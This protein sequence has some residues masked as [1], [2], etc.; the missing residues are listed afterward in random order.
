LKLS[1][2]IPAYNEEACL[3]GCLASIIGRIEQAGADAEVIVV[4]NGSTDATRKIALSFPG[5]IV[6][7]EPIKGLSRA[8]QAGYRAGTGDLIANVDADNMLPEGWLEKVLAEFSGNDRLVALS[9]PL[10]YYD[11]PRSRRLCTTLFYCIG[12]TMYLLSHYVLRRG[13]MLQGGNFV[14]R[15]S[16]LEAIGGYNTE[17]AFYGEDTDV[18][19]RMQAAGRIKFTFRLPMYSSG[20]RFAKE[21]IVA[22]GFRYALNYLWIMVFKRPYHRSSTD[23]RPGSDGQSGLLVC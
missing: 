16:A 2:V 11:L 8:R 20:R 6:V 10:A 23:V 7:D 3:A 21:G 19:R 1:F 12:Y 13:G 4:N 15:R 22:T 18:A 9:G 5:V 14:L 17:I